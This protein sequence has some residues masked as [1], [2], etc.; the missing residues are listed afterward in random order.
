MGFSLE[1]SWYFIDFFIFFRIPST[2]IVLTYWCH[3]LH[4]QM[5]L[6]SQLMASSFQRRTWHM[7]ATHVFPLRPWPSSWTLESHVPSLHQCSRYS[8]C[9][10]E[11]LYSVV[12]HL[13][14]CRICRWPLL[15]LHQHVDR[16]RRNISCDTI[17]SIVIIKLHRRYFPNGR[18][19]FSGQARWCPIM[20]MHWIT[21]KAEEM[22]WAKRLIRA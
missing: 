21:S 9:I 22:L 1:S 7:C 8:G 3:I 4:H 15:L 13:C 17:L 14:N 20:R 6:W 18:D 5:L 11:E 12:P 10:W 16:T 19:L 2:I